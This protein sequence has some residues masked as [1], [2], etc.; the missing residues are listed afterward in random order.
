MDV[1]GVDGY[2]TG[3][4]SKKTS[5]NHLDPAKNATKPEAVFGPALERP[6]TPRPPT[7]F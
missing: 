7:G 6:Y 3:S 4:C 5:G 1:V 2:A